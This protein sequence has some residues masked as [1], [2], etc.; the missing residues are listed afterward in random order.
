MAG[1]CVLRFEALPRS[2]GAGQIAVSQ[3]HRRQEADAPRLAPRQ[4]RLQRLRRPHRQLRLHAA[5]R[6][7][8]LDALQLGQCAVVHPGAGAPPAACRPPL[9]TGRAGRPHRPRTHR[10]QPQRPHLSRRHQ[11]RHGPPGLLDGHLG[12]GP[13]Q[14]VEIDTVGL[15][16]AQRGVAGALDVAGP[17]VGDDVL[18]THQQPAL[19]RHERVRPPLLEH[20]AHQ[21]LVGERAVHIGGVQQA[22]PPVQCGVR[23]PQRAVQ[24]ALRLGV[25]PAHRH[26]AEPYGAH[27]ESRRT[28]CPALHLVVPPSPRPR[29]RA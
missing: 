24:A 28:D 14:L 20:P 2:E 26:T 5:D 6:E 29:S 23:G 25:P 15:Q 21:Q 12:I 7:H 19:G 9:R 1:P 4:Q 3:R 22:A 11:L 16:P 8:L 17:P 13:V 18:L 10:T 27:F